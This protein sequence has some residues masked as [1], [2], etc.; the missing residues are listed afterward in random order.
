MAAARYWRLVGIETL[1]GGDLELSAI[2]LY[3]GGARVDGTA[4][5]TCSHAPT[6]GALAN[7]QD[8][9]SATT[10]LFAG[11]SVRSG[12]FYLQWDF[13]SAAD[14]G[15]VKLGGAA[16]A[17]F[18]SGAILLRASTLGDW[19]QVGAFAGALY[20]G[21][22]ALTASSAGG[23][24]PTTWNPLDKGASAALSNGNLTAQVYQ[25][26]AVRSVF[27]A[28]SGKWYWELTTDNSYAIAG[29]SKSSAALTNYPGGVT[30]SWGY[31][32]GAGT[33]GA[34]GTGF[35]AYGVTWGS[36][37]TLGIALNLDSGT[38][39]YFV[40][41]VSLGIAFTGLS[42]VIF[43]EVGGA[44]NS[45]QATITAN[46]GATAFAYAPPAGFQAGFGPT[47]IQLPIT[48]LPALH[49]VISPIRV[50]AAAGVEAFSTRAR[51]RLAT[52]R[53]MEFGGAGRIWGTTKIE[54]SP[55]VRTPAKGRVSILRERD[56][57]LARQ[58]WSDPVTGEWEVTG[59]DTSQSFIELAQ[60][61][62]GTYMP[63]AADRT[64]P[65]ATP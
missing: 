61:P 9:D 5:L 38:L 15:E 47:A 29:I 36:G 18:A 59:L 26:G 44:T 58:V 19:T 56:K 42:G 23:A 2:A 62:S 40:Q 41:G 53:D 12:G 35:V 43:A 28:A 48:T 65:E 7:L 14:I 50:A 4:T 1:G 25:S 24:T 20:P 22:G 51:G 54:T 57:L 32:G 17:R 52:A 45:A 31:Y 21:D 39:E 33:K 37:K 34:N 27:G 10:T 6:A 60:D 55:G 49:T 8:T 3:A 11:A 16:A 63:A 13:G 30:D 64:L 46:F